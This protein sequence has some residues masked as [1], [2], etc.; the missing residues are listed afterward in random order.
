M[1]TEN[2]RIARATCD[3]VVAAC[4]HGG[5]DRPAGGPNQAL[6]NQRPIENPTNRHPA[7][8]MAREPIGFGAR[9]SVMAFILS[10]PFRLSVFVR[11]FP[12]PQ[13]GLADATRHLE[14]QRHL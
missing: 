4:R 14:V 6:A 2:F 10:P 13:F 8:S 11:L 3:S 7:S 12:Q 5:L 1:K 9:I